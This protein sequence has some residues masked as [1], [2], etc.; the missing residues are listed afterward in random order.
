MAEARDKTASRRIMEAWREAADD[1]GIRVTI[2]FVLTGPD[3]QAIEF[4]ALVHDFGAPGGAL[5]CSFQNWPSLK[6]PV[7]GH[8][9]FLSGLNPDSY[10]RY[11]RQHFIDTL[12]DWG[13][14]G[15]G[16]RPSWYTGID[17]CG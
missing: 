9:Y 11:D 5:V 17:P 7:E 16:A 3:A 2:P 13:W 4:I 6:E 12:E 14:F 1:L 15:K 10:S 8:G